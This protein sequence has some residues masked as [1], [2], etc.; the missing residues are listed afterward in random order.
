MHHRSRL[1]GLP[2]ALALA[3]QIDADSTQ[4]SRMGEPIYLLVKKL[5]LA[6]RTWIDAD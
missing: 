2:L 3:L 4:R 5:Y 6:A 1:Q